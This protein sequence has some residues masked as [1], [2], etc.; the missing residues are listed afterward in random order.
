MHNLEEPGP[1]KNTLEK[2][3]V[4]CPQLYEFVYPTFGTWWTSH[5]KMVYVTKGYGKIHWIFRDLKCLI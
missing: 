2:T 3:V 4:S 1:S 5:L